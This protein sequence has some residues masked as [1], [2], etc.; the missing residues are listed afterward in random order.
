MSDQHAARIRTAFPAG[1]ADD[2]KGADGRIPVSHAGVVIRDDRH[3]PRM[4]AGQAAKEERATGRF[5]RQDHDD[6][7]RF[8]TIW[9]RT[10]P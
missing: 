6:P 1:P 4:T 5:Q 9:V 2:T 8:H 10:K 7:V 3:L